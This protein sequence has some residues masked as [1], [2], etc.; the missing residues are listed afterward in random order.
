MLVFIEGHNSAAAHHLTFERGF[1]DRVTCELHSVSAAP[2]VYLL[3]EVVYEQLMHQLVVV[4][5]ELLRAFKVIEH[6][7]KEGINLV[8]VCFFEFSGESV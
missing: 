6:C 4:V 7:R 2:V 8:A 1:F 5:T 3:N